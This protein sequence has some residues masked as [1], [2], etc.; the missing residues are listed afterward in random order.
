MDDTALTVRETLG[1]AFEGEWTAGADLDLPAA[2]E[3]GV[4]ALGG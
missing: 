2:V 3:V 1:D 4:R